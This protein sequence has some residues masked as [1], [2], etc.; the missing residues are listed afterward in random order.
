[1]GGEGEDDEGGEGE[2]REL[3]CWAT[4]GERGVDC[5]Y[6]CSIVGHVRS[7]FYSPGYCHECHRLARFIRSCL[8]NIC[9]SK[10]YS[11]HSE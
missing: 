1:M 10:W 5:C 2:V 7:W 11:C 8:Y 6:R 4:A 3:G 9:H